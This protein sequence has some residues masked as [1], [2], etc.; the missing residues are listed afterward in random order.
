MNSVGLKNEI[1]EHLSVDDGTAQQIIQLRNRKEDLEKYFETYPEDREGDRF[2]E[3]LK[4]ADRQLDHKRPYRIAIIGATGAGKSS[5]ANAL[6]ARDLLPAQ[7]ARATTGTVLEIHQTPPNDNEIAKLTYR[8]GQDVW[9]FLETHFIK[10]FQ[11]NGEAWSEIKRTKSIDENLKEAIDSVNIPNGNNSEEFK[12][13]KKTCADM[14]DQFIQQHESLENDKFSLNEKDDLEGLNNLIDEN[15]E[16]NQDPRTRRIGL[17]KNVSYYIPLNEALDIPKTACLIDLPGLGATLL[18]D[19]IIHK[20]VDDADA[21]VF[22]FDTPTRMERQ[23]ELSL[24][25]RITKNISINSEQIFL[26][27]NKWDQIVHDSTGKNIESTATKVAKDIAK[28]LGLDPEDKSWFF[29]VSAT[30]ARMAQKQSENSKEDV[31]DNYR[32]FAKHSGHVDLNPEEVLKGTEI[33]ELAGALRTLAKNNVATRIESA[34]GA[35]GSILNMLE[36]KHRSNEEL[37][38]LKERLL[39]ETDKSNS[40][41]LDRMQEEMLVPINEFK[42]H[43]INKR[44]DLKQTLESEFDAICNSVNEQLRAACPDMWKSVVIDTDQISGKSVS[45]LDSTKFITKTNIKV[46]HLL[47]DKLV[48][49]AKKTAEYHHEEFSTQE[50]L[51]NL[52]AK[53]A[54]LQ[55]T[56]DAFPQEYI[57]EHVEE[58]EENLSQATKRSAVAILCDPKCFFHEMKPDKQL[59]VEPQG[60]KPMPSDESNQ[61][62]STDSG[63]AK[64]VDSID[65][66]WNE[67]NTEGSGSPKEGRFEKIVSCIADIYAPLVKSNIIDG[68]LNIYLYERVRIDEMLE[69]KVGKLIR[70]L[71]KEGVLEPLSANEPEAVKSL[72]AEIEAEELREK[73]R[74]A[75]KDL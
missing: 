52:I 15:S 6:L 70:D 67:E 38:D 62:S 72:R 34:R 30:M 64:L 16:M 2:N 12:E 53:G 7:P 21:V 68:L 48:G 28:K 57:N 56:Q 54:N 40:A 61:Q 9:D 13:A 46:W 36:K 20:N 41:A 25:V 26:V 65:T 27:F 42:T 47:S 23:D 10:R 74:Q 44:S 63:K 51:E 33:P 75:L 59:E 19:E 18:H 31:S 39:D 37:E 29:P 1:I 60:Q 14:V 35:L 71:R 73:K 49:L 69:E 58:L 43:Q 5:V 50:V 32:V 55:A 66:F 8:S 22:V 17:I 11:I 3:N 45:K 4:L 24:M